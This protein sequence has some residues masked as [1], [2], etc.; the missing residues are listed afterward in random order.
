M[1]RLFASLLCAVALQAGCSEAL[2]WRAVDHMIAAEY[3]DVTALTTDSLAARLADDTSPTPV[4]LDARSPDEY[5]VSHLPGARRVRPS[6]DAYPALDTLASDTPI[7]V[8][9]S[10]GYRS[11][12]VVQA[13]QTQGFS[14]VYNLKGSIF[15]WANEGR[16]VVRNG[17]PVSAVHPYD[18]SWGQ[19]LTDS[20]RAS[21]SSERL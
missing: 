3:P 2:T 5:A 7:L 14:E 18:A 1:R 21:P 15:R 13:L 8:Y 16:P 6:A 17:E 9:C 4:L 11:A 10:V 20:L 19:L 12:G